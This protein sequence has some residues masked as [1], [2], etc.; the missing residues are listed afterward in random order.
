MDRPYRS[1]WSPPRRIRGDDVM[2]VT[3]EKAA[4]SLFVRP[5]AVVEP[6]SVMPV[7]AVRP[8]SGR[9]AEGGHTLEPGLEAVFRYTVT[10]DGTS[11]ALGS[12]TSP[13]GP[14]RGCPSPSGPP[15]PRSPG[16]GSG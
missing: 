1:R 10:E 8:S 7:Q 5:G 3:D 9:A 2:V 6:A 16:P 13:C 12:A 11:A 4:L 14:P 15:L